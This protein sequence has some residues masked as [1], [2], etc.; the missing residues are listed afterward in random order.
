M[1]TVLPAP[2]PVADGAVTQ[3]LE[4]EPADNAR[5]ARL[6]GH[7]DEHLRQI[8]R[9]LG[10]EIANRGGRFQI[11]G[12]A[13]AVAVATAVVEGLY[14]A[15]REEEINPAMVHLFLQ[16]AGADDIELPESAEAE[17]EEVAIRTRR[18][19]VRG[20]GGVRGVDSSPVGGGATR[21]VPA[22]GRDG[23]GSGST[24]TVGSTGGS[25]AGLGRTGAL[26]MR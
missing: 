8:E 21:S 4:L 9:R 10:I 12:P 25:G 2:Q 20:P 13:V 5:L 3:V 23:G 18:G 6:C 16:E 22:S 1:N 14:R 19:I 26:S 7:L 11:E 17:P 15:A 24:A